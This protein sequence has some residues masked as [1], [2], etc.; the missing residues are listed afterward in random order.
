MSDTASPIAEF[1]WSG[2]IAYGELRLFESTILVRYVQRGHSEFEGSFSL[3]TLR[4]EYSTYRYRRQTFYWA[5]LFIAI[6]TYFWCIAAFAGNL[7]VVSPMA[8]VMSLLMVGALGFAVTQARLVTCYWFRRHSG[9]LAF[10]VPALGKYRDQC[11]HFVGEVARQIQIG[12]A[13]GP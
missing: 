6:L 11:E 9:E 4:P 12:R 13:T 2:L 8:L 1:R 7:Q 5:V 10:V 3:D